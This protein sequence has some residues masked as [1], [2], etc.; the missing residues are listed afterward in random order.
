[1][2]NIRA[3]LDT[4]IRGIDVSTHNH[5]SWE[6]CYTHFRGPSGNRDHDALHLGFF[7]ASWGMYRKSGF[8]CNHDYTIHKAAIAA[9]RR[10]KFNVL[11]DRNF[12]Y[13]ARKTHE[14][15]S[16]TILQ[17]ADAVRE[18]YAEH[19]TKPKKVTDTL[20][21]KVLLGMRGCLPACDRFFI[22]GFRE[23]GRHYS[24]LNGRFVASVFAF[25]RSNLSALQS[26]Q[27]RLKR[28]LGARYPLMKL[29]DMY[30]HQIGRQVSVD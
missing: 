19:V 22:A 2:R 21:S 12:D 1:M 11:W 14:T 17:A 30:F 4:Y 24:G 25:C 20:V 28:E 13:G 5:N 26:E 23:E 18:A 15:V 6:H 10:P 9:L 8:I 3:T 29:V 7:L 16:T 27:R